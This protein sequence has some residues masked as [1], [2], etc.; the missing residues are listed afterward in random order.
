MKYNIK[1]CLFSKRNFIDSFSKYLTNEELEGVHNHSHHQL[2]KK[3]YPIF[4]QDETPKGLIYLQSGSAKVYKYKS[5]KREQI[6]RFA[7]HSSFV[8]YKALFAEIKHTTTATAIE[9][10]EIVIIDK[11]FLFQLMDKNS[12]FSRYIIKALSNELSY[13]YER[14]INLTQKHLRG[15]MAETIVLLSEIYGFMDDDKTIDITIT[16]ENLGFFSNMTTANA[17]RTIKSFEKEGL[18]NS[19]N[20]HIQILKLEQIKKIGALG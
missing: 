19:S 6:V 13:N 4:K 5:G 12:K 1:A 15:R 11:D 9:D 10:S 20:H 3:G 14:L 8:G 7:G 2:I 16:R 17:I 18:I